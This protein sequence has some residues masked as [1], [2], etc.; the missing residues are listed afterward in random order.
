MELRPFR[1]YRFNAEVV[2]DAGSCIAPPYDVISDSEREELYRKNE[3]NIVRI[4]KGKAYPSDNGQHNQY[5]RA[6]EYF[7]SWIERGVLKQ[8]ASEAIYGYVQDF[9]VEGKDLRRLSFISLAK[10]EELGKTVRPH[11]QV[12]DKPVA[13]R[14]NLRRATK[15]WFGLVFMLYEDQEKVADNIIRKVS[16]RKPII[17]FVDDQQVRQ[18]L[19]AMT[20]KDDV[21]KIVTMM[22]DKSCIIADGHHRYTTGLTY[23]KE[24]LGPEAKYQMIGFTNWLQKGLKVLATHRLVGDLEGFDKESFIK[25]L[26]EKFEISTFEFADEQGKAQAKTQM[27]RK[28]RAEH[29]KGRNAFGIYCGGNA[30]YVA[31]LRNKSLMDAAAPA[32]SSAIR[33]LDVAVLQKLMFEQLLGID[34]EKVAQGNHVEYVKDVPAAI[35]ECILLVDKREKQAAFFTNPVRMEQLREVTQAG[36][37]MPHKSTYF[38]PKMYTGLTIQKL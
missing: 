30:F 1:A 4:S 31:V 20:D 16:R 35:D 17:D 5:T 11:E 26:C 19:F 25:T 8:D 21:D 36:E 38:F 37:R 22:R 13:D 28:M 34:E 24:N 2:G 3:Y 33:G 12:F 6:A 7:K 23:S 29:N 18:R 27:L 14:L 9:E 10:L 32:V 15:A